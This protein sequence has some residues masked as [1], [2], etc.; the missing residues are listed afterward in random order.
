[1]VE[2]FDRG[3]SS[4]MNRRQD[5]IGEGCA[6]QWKPFENSNKGFSAMMQPSPETR[7]GCAEP[8]KQSAHFTIQTL[9]L[10]CPRCHAI[11]WNCRSCTASHSG[12][13][14]SNIALKLQ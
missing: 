13:N 11:Q 14:R 7:P 4:L 3:L 10:P 6:A 5:L 8:F 2:L 1:M 12:V 9:A